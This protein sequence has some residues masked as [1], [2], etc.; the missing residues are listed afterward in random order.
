MAHTLLGEHCVSGEWFRCAPEIAI[1]AVKSA[2]VNAVVMRSKPKIET[3]GRPALPKGAK[4][5]NIVNVRLNNA[6]LARLI[7][8]RMDLRL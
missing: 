3:R 4:R 5:D 6:E 7:H 8:S 2:E 1:A